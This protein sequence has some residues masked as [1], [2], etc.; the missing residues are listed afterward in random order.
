MT[1]RQIVQWSYTEN[2]EF[3]ARYL[4]QHVPLI[5]KLPG[6]ERLFVAPFRSRQLS[7]MAELTFSGLEELKKAFATEEAD[8]L[9]Q[10]VLDLEQEFG[11]KAVSLIAL[12]PLVNDGARASKRSSMENQTKPT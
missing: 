5:R 12:E 10:D 8:A 3:V 4:A 2:E 9:R 1:V 11:V 7:L 6:L